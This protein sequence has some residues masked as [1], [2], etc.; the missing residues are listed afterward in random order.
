MNLSPK[1]QSK[2]N[3]LSALLN[4]LLLTILILYLILTFLGRLKP[5][6]AYNGIT[7]DS[8]LISAIILIIITATLNKIMSKSRI[9]I[10][11]LSPVAKFSIALILILTTGG[12]VMTMSQFP[13]GTR[14]ILAILTMLIALLTINF[15]SLV[16]EK[17]Q[18]HHDLNHRL[19]ELHRAGLVLIGLLFVTNLLYRDI[20]PTQHYVATPT[21]PSSLIKES[22]NP[23][24][25]PTIWQNNRLLWLINQPTARFLF[26]TRDIYE[27]LTIRVYYSSNKPEKA[28]VRTNNTRSQPIINLS[29]ITLFDELANPNWSWPRTSWK[30]NPSVWL[31]TKPALPP[32]YPSFEE[33]IEDNTVNRLVDEAAVFVV[34]NDQ[35]TEYQSII[36]DFNLPNIAYLL[37]PDPDLFKSNDLKK[38]GDQKY[39]IEVT[40]QLTEEFRAIGVKYPID[41]GI[42]G[43][44]VGDWM[45]VEKIEIIATRNP[46]TLDSVGSFIKRRLPL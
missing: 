16:T 25:S 15:T 38:V 1:L 28:F 7:S 30:N 4:D 10:V 17:E 27:S 22:S 46:V 5:S 32:G 45:T 19:I 24:D 37:T 14:T 13:P 6:L 18:P 20:Q 33:F 29:A 11:Y 21:K 3:Y 26:P 34:K 9:T 43:F 23:N 40:S 8:L 42:D 2:L 12:I 41:I 39:L 35:N 44:N 31:Y 36:H